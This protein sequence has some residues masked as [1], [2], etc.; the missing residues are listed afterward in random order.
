MRFITNPDKVIFSIGVGIVGGLFI[1][2]Y[3][4]LNRINILFPLL[5][6]WIVFSL[7]LIKINYI[8][9]VVKDKIITIKSIKKTISIKFSDI[10]YIIQVN[11][12]LNM[13]RRRKYKLIVNKFYINE[14]LLEIESE[15]FSKWLLKNTKEFKILKQIK[16][17]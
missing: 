13:L 12:G 10:D 11:H 7:F 1:Y 9:Y 5:I 4:F 6:L 3:M 16:Y 14:K 8:E 2:L 15:K 17:D